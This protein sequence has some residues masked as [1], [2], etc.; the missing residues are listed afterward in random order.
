MK[1]FAE[2][3]KKALKD[4]GVKQKE[5]AVRI[6]MSEAGLIKMIANGS[7]QVET[8][9][10]ICEELEIPIT[11]FLEVD[12]KPEGFWKKLVEDTMEELNQWKIRAY[13]A[14]S[15]LTQSGN[16]KYVSRRQGVLASV[17]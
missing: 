15:Q 8:L 5:L 4:K 1:N 10:K 9:E 13:K 3:L 11:Y 2:K 7:V 12:I 17:A 14:E 16:F 6:G